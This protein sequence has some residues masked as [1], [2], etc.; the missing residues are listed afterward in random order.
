[1]SRIGRL[2]ILLPKDV[3]VNKDSENIVVKGPHGVLER[4][5]PSIIDVEILDDRLIVTTKTQS[6]LSREFHGL[7]RT[8][9]NNMVI[10]VSEKFDKQL[11]LK[12]VGYRCQ[13]N[14]NIITLNLGYSHPI[15]MKIPD[16]IDV[17]VENNSKNDTIEN[18]FD[19]NQDS[20]AD[21][22]IKNDV[23]NNVEDIHIR[24]TPLDHP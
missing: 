17:K 15:E 23:K 1:M 13:A 24:P 22:I 18:A 9:I 21:S 14:N 16:Q 2:P 4:E 8:L 7:F 11:E 12:G 3:S 19:E 5:I 10:G 20:K 6:R